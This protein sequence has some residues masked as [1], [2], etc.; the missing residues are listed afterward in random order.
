MKNDPFTL[1][2]ALDGK[3]TARGELYLDDGESFSYRNGHLLWRE[4]IAQKPEKKTIRVSSRDLAHQNPGEV[5][6]GVALAQYNP[7]N[8]FVKSIE[9]VRV[10]RVVAVGLSGKP[11]SV[12][13]EGGGE[14]EWHYV[15]GVSAGDRKEGVASVLT[16]KD[17]NVSVSK[18]WAIVILM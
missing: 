5:V 16:V 7:T 2:V 13:V 10:E 4:F 8:V 18:D 17:P 12:R 9:E 3:G 15:A 14:L 11:K 1:R 6:D